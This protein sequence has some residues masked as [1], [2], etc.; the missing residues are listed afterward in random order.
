MTKEFVHEPIL[1]EPTEEN[2]FINQAGKTVTFLLGTDYFIGAP[3]TNEQ[4]VAITPAQAHQLKSWLAQLG[5]DLKL[6]VV[7]DAGLRAGFPDSDYEAAGARIIGLEKLPYMH[8]HPHVVHA[9]K[10]STSYE[11]TIPGHFLRIGAL[12][13][14]DFR[15][16]CGLAEVLKKGNYSA[17]FDGSAVGGFAYKTDFPIKPSFRVPLRSSMSVYAGWLAGEDVGDALGERGER[18]VISGGG[19]VGTSA[20][21]VLL[22]KNRDQLSEILIIEKF[23]ERCR[24]LEEQYAEY[25]NL[26]RIK[27]GTTIEDED[28][29]GARGLILT[30]FIQ[31]SGATPKV[32]NT[33]Q[34]KLMAENGHVVDVAI[35]E[36]GGVRTPMDD[37]IDPRTHKPYVVT[38]EDIKH[39][40]ASLGKGLSYHADNHMPRRRPHQAS[41]EHGRTALM[42][43]AA[44][45]YCCA[46]KDGT[47]GALK[48]IMDQDYIEEPKSIFAALIL[49]L[50]HGLAFSNMN[51]V[52]GVY[53]HVLKKSDEIRQ[54]LVDNGVTNLFV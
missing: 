32:T 8:D 40:V 18:V 36:G 46:A 19:V 34:I 2:G 50:K 24:Q 22:E 4:R 26:V 42:Y 6:Y 10:E 44:L 41:I 20:A 27:E 17:V 37:K 49:D 1:P 31:G 3:H 11:A 14:G 23:P 47:E 25:G 39:A 52:T 35:D 51:N 33:E 38:I 21:D 7:R 29:R 48:Y 45:L 5:I 15:P 12:H 53:R 13:S 28:L 30:I 54:F 43:L 9:L 16:D